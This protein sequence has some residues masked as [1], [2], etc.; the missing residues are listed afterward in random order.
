VGNG[1]RHGGG[2]WICPDARID[3]GLLD[4]CVCDGLGKLQIAGFL[5]R[6][7][8][9]THVGASCVHMRRARRVRITSAT[10]LPVHADGEILFEDAREL[11][12]EVAPGCLR[13]LGSTQSTNG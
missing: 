1:G 9:G 8:R 7:L 12:V 10:P 5:P 11:L 2:F 4:V 13:L 6:T 3:D